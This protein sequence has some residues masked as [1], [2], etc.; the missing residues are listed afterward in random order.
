[1]GKSVDRRPLASRLGW[2]ILLWAGGVVSVGL[3][4]Y[5]IRTVL[6]G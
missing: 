3:V 4:G 5:A 1:M 6:G 2:F